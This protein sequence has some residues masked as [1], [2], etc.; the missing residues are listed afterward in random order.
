MAESRVSYG[1]TNVLIRSGISWTGM[2]VTSLIAFTSIAVIDFV[3]QV[4]T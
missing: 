3:P 2:R 4:E 1:S